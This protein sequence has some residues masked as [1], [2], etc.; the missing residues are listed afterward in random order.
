MEGMMWAVGALKRTPL[1]F[2]V[3]V[4]SG[5]GEYFMYAEFGAVCYEPDIES[6]VSLTVYSSFLL[7][8]NSQQC[9][10]VLNPAAMTT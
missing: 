6:N 2:W 4:K 1:E 10:G 7:Q 5:S 3:C 9:R 8:T